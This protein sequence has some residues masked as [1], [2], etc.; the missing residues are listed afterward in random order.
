MKCNSEHTINCERSVL[1]INSAS[2]IIFFYNLPYSQSAVFTIKS[3]T[4]GRDKI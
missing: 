3:A 2:N 4:D 1:I